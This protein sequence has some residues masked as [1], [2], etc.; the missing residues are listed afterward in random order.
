MPFY[1]FEAEDGE[2]IEEYMNMNEMKDE[3]QRKD[4]KYKRIPEFGGSFIL[5]GAG[6]A[7]KNTSDV[8]P[9]RKTKADVGV[10][11]DYDK[12]KQMQEAGE[13]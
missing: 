1:L 8:G 6:W 9:A 10:K 2:Q 13:I 11:V 5:K 3:I 4:K 12:K 7:S